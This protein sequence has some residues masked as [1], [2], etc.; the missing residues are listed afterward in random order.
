M[1]REEF[2]RHFDVSRE[3]LERL[4][5]YAALLRK[6]SR[7]INLIGPIDEE[8]LWTRHIIDAGQLVEYVIDSGELA[9]IGSGAGLPG[10]VL[11]ILM[12][13]HDTKVHLIESDQRKCAFLREAGRQTDT[14]INVVAERVEN[15][16]LEVDTITA[17][18]VAPLHRLLPMCEKIA[19]ANTRLIL[20]KG[21]RVSEEIAAVED[22]WELTYQMHP[23]LTGDTSAILVVDSFRRKAT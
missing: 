11:A 4:D 15:I 7:A 19:A 16:D 6:W 22:D 14:V 12:D 3:T 9:D 23:S 8:A 5:I 18:A 1:N 2:A 20:P 13:D 21:E 10:L 17:R